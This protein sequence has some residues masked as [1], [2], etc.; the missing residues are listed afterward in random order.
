MDKISNFFILCDLFII[1]SILFVFGIETTYNHNLKFDEIK[2]GSNS[3]LK[4]K[5]KAIG[6]L[7]ENNYGTITFY[8][9]LIP[10]ERSFINSTVLIDIDDVSLGNTF[11]DYLKN[12]LTCLNNLTN[13]TL[14]KYTIVI[15]GES[16]F[17]DVDGGSGSI[18]L[19]LGVLSALYNKTI[20]ENVIATGTIN[21][22]CSISTVLG[23]KEKLIG[24]E[25]LGYKKFYIPYQNYKV[26]EGMNSSIKVIPVKNLKEV[27]NGE[28]K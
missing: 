14:K 9:Y 8:I 7:D 10:K 25:N 20:N 12:T 26:I 1:V 15:K 11:Q 16:K 5:I 24:V 27:L 13:N 18:M 2:L 4:S 17:K 6:V 28:L 23:V 21:P 3:V 19:A 22:D